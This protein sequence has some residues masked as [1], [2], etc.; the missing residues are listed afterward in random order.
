MS[1]Y[2]K[3]SDEELLR[4]LGQGTDNPYLREL[5][6]RFKAAKEERHRSW[7]EPEPLS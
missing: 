2:R 4:S 5:I 7:I 3:M 6:R 1:V